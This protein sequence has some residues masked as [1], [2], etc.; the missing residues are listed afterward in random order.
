ME[1]PSGVIVF[2][3]DEL[4]TATEQARTMAKTIATNAVLDN[5][6]TTF[7]SEVVGD[8]LERDYATSLYNQIAVKSGGTEIETIGGLYTVEV[9]YDSDVIYTVNGVEADNE[10]DACEQVSENISI[11]DVTLN[12]V[13]SYDTDAEQVE[14]MYDRA[15]RIQ[16]SLEFSASE[17]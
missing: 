15:Y 14:V 9:T 2:T 17:E 6:L 1:T 10:D 3:Q 5:V 4:N 8:N 11:D 12:F 13:I 7:R 16:E